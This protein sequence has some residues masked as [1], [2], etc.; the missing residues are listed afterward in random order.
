[1]KRFIKLFLIIM[2]VFVFTA[3]DNIVT[4][5][6]GVVI[7]VN[8]VSENDNY[9]SLEKKYVVVVE[10]QN[11]YRQFKYSLYTNQV[12]TVGDIIEFKR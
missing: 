5:D 9:A 7:S 1:M 2:A 10:V 8:K 3:C 12:Y 4:D 6:K 11:K